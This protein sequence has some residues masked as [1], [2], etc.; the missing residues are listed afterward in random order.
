MLTKIILTLLVIVGALWFVSNQR[1]GDR[2]QV[3]AIA[4]KK[5]QQNRQMLQRG[6]YVFMAIMLLAAAVMIY[7]ELSDSA[8]TVTVHVVNTQTGTRTSYQA[9]REDIQA[10][11][12]TTLDGR[13]VYVAGVERIEVE[14]P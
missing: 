11:S 2:Q 1:R 14:A 4:S 3:L 5:E 9:R 13:S 7:V 12:F 10:G 8:T 6:T